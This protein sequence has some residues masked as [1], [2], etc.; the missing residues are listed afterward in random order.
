L[1]ATNP[2]KACHLV[3]GLRHRIQY[4]QWCN[5]FIWD[6]WQY[7]TSYNPSNRY[8]GAKV[9]HW[10]HTYYNDAPLQDN[11]VGQTSSRVPESV[12]EPLESRVWFNYPGQWLNEFYNQNSIGVGASNKP[13]VIARVLDD[14][15][16]Q[17]WRYQYNGNGRLTQITDPVGRKLT[18]NYDPNGIDLLTVTNTTDRTAT[19]KK[20]S[21]LLLSLSNYNSQHEPQQIVAANGQATTFAYNAAGQLHLGQMPSATHGR[22]ATA[23]PRRATALLEPREAT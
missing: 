1:S 8:L 7:K 9:I 3:Q 14:G 16:T 20:Y 2:H 11:P 6:P 22:C 18:M 21:D 10:L 15:T 23:F 19:V 13:T 4:L 12:K 5:T 17:V